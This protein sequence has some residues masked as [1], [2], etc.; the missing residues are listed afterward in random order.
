MVYGK[1]VYD[2]AVP[3]TPVKRHLVSDLTFLQTLLGSLTTSFP[4]L[5]TATGS[6][7]ATPNDF[8]VEKYPQG[9]KEKTN[10]WVS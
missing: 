1:Q 10:G 5:V 6:S 9:E 8:G 3:I 4:P 2:P 7:A